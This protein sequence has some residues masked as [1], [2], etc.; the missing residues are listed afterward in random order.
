MGVHIPI[1]YA[2]AGED[3]AAVPEDEQLVVLI[4]DV[5]NPDATPPIAPSIAFHSLDVGTASEQ[6]FPLDRVS[7]IFST[8]AAVKTKYDGDP[9]SGAGQLPV[10]DA[11]G[12]VDDP[13]K[14][15][16]DEESFKVH[17][18]GAGPTAGFHTIGA[19]NDAREELIRLGY[20]DS[21]VPE[22]STVDPRPPATP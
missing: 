12:V 7:S 9:S 6:R 2:F 8:A 5:G 17:L 13:L 20:L 21:T 15:G 22:V 14:A 1:F 11:P 10:L 19:W 18:K 16:F 3:R 4:D